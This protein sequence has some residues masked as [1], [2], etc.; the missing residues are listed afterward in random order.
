MHRG[1]VHRQ[2]DLGMGVD[3]FRYIFYPVAEWLSTRVFF[4]ELFNRRYCDHDSS[5]PRCEVSIE[6]LQHVFERSY[7]L[8]RSCN[9][10]LSTPV[11]W[12]WIGEITG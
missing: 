11:Q 12:S 6:M 10:L 5:A 1:V 7:V 4:P 3:C 8:D 2:C 9:E